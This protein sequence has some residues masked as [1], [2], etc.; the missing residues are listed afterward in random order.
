MR[1]RGRRDPPHGSRAG[2]ARRGPSC[3]DGSAPARR[4]SARWPAGWSTCSTCSRAISTARA[5][6]CSRSPPPVRANAQGPPGA[7]RGVKFGR[8]HSRVRGLPEVYG[9]LPSPCLAE[10]IDTPGEGQIRALITI[11]G[12]PG[13]STPNSD[14]LARGLQGLDF[15]LCLDVYVNE[16]SRHADVILPGPTPLCHSHYDLAFYQLAVRNIA[17]YTPAVLAP[18]PRDPGGVGDAAA[19]DRDRDRGGPP[20]RRR[21]DR[22]LRRPRDGATR[23][24]PAP[25]RAGRPR[26]RGARGRRRRA[27][28]PRATARPAAALWPLRRRFRR[29]RRRPH[30]GRPGGGAPRHRPRPVSAAHPRGPADAQRPHR[31][32]P[33]G[34]RRRSAS[35]A[36]RPDPARQRWP[37]SHRAPPAA[38]QQLLDAQP[39]AAGPGQGELHRPRPPRRRGTA[40]AGRRRARAGQLARRG[41]RGAGAGHRRG[42]AG[43]GEHSPRVGAR[44]RRR[45]HVRRLRARRGELQHAR[46][47]DAHRPAIGQCRAQ[48]HPDRA[49]RPPRTLRYSSTK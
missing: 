17:H 25:G 33:R 37:G 32:R 41:H 36:Q 8:W 45:A 21:G 3:T 15:M 47:R 31:A 6:R 4:S 44:P 18:R 35:P 16:T 43:R 38:L 7:G 46:R 9:E 42:D 2:A 20:R 13:L 48:R 5:G 22:P 49:R 24:R 29:A 23:D 14:R 19:P 27:P 28:R 11:A 34:D 26:P 39:R 12:N 1:D 40:R 10:E 30:P